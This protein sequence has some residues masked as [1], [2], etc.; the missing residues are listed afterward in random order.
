M[1]REALGSTLMAGAM[2]VRVL[3]A[4]AGRILAALLVTPVMAAMA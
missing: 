4:A 1:A 3:V 2:A